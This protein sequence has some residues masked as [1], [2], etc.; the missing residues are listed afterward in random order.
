M[1]VERDTDRQLRAWASEGVDRAPERFVWAALDEIETVPQRTAWRTQIGGLAIGLRPAAALVGAAAVIL[2]AIAILARVVAPNLGVGVP[3]QFETADLP[4]I[5][6]W[7][8]TIP[9]GW[10]LDNL[11]SNPWEVSV[12]PIRSMTGAEIE[13]HPEP[14][15]LV[16]GRFVNGLG[17]ELA[18]MSWSALFESEALAGA[19]LPFYER[20]MEASDAWGLGP[21]EPIAFG[22]GGHVF[23]GPTTAFLGPPTGVDPTPARI[24]LWRDGNLLLAVGGFGEY[25]AAELRAVADAMNARAAAVSQATEPSPAPTGETAI[26]LASIV[27]PPDAAPVGLHHDETG[28]GREALTMLIVSGR[29]AEFAAVDGFVDARWTTFSGDPGALLSLAMAF[30]D[31]LTGD[32]AYHLFAGELSSEDGY[33]FGDLEL[34]DLGFEGTCDT[35]G[36]PE[37]DG[38]VETICI[39]RGASFVMIAGGSLPPADLKAIAAAMDARLP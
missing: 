19:A 27:V 17:P 6:L 8:D 9:A 3:R 36:N 14:E 20:E 16:A 4:G 32:V 24:Y 22:D 12:I 30:E 23:S 18:F 10:T 31:S 21:G 33:G 7:E 29:E 34:A 25:D 37:L 2:V 39:W 13:A 1:N 11:Y 38:L 28:A 35:G 26:D 15:G 5:V